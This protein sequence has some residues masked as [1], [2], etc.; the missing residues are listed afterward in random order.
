M[1]ML[2]SRGFFFDDDE[3]SCLT[4]EMKKALVEVY[5]E[6]SIFIVILNSIPAMHIAQIF[7][8]RLEACTQRILSGE[9]HWAYKER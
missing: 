4:Y 2:L 3:V 7:I 6:G 5:F 9:V 8:S 1:E